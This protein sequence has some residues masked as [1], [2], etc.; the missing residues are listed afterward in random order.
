MQTQDF[1]AHNEE[2]RAVWAAYRAGAPVRVP[3]TLCTDTRF[4]ILDDEFNP[5]ERISFRAYSEDPLVMMDFQLRAAEW[6]AYNVA[7]LCDDQAGLPDKFTV[8]VDLQRYFEA[9]FFGATVEYRPGQ[10]P[11]TQPILAGDRKHALFDRGLPHPLT[12]GVFAKAHRFHEAMA[13]RIGSGFTYRDR[14]VEF[15]PSGLTST[16]GPLTVATN[17]RGFE[18]YTDFYADPDYVRQLLDFIVEGTIVRV[19]AQR[20]FFGLPEVSE[21]WGYADDA[22]QMI[23]TDMV[24]EFAVPA[25][26]KLKQALTS[27]GRISI[28]LCGDATRHFKLLRDELGVCSFDTGFPVDFA[29]LRS[30]LGPEVEILGG[31][32]VTVLRNG[33]PEQVAAEVKRILSSGITEGGR[34]ILREANDLAP[35]TTLENL[36]AMYDTARKFGRYDQ[37]HRK[38]E[39]TFDGGHRPPESANPTIRSV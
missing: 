13:K 12:G 33:T 10:T 8:T 9:G 16:D 11:D 26:R 23:S 2:A 19:R 29:W 31:P 7:P 28:H 39:S 4:F 30:D 36:A 17:L 14:L 37:T 25:H 27:A 24:R 38:V 22:V 21:R 34:F 32:R 35:G 1:A 6:R 3:V 20:R 5:G 18:L 15:D